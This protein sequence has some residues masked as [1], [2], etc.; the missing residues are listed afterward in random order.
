MD[1]LTG[2]GFDIRVLEEY[3]DS[4][5]TVLDNPI[6]S[7]FLRDEVALEIS[8]TRSVLT[9]KQREFEQLLDVANDE[10]DDE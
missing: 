2:L 7:P 6:M 1:A 8:A 5:D 9:D 4:L 3:L 10:E